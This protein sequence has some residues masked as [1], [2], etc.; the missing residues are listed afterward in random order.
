MVSVARVVVTDAAGWQREM[1][2]GTAGLP[3]LSSGGGNAT[4]IWRSGGVSAGCGRGRLGLVA[5]AGEGLGPERAAVSAER[6][7]AQTVEAGAGAAADAWSFVARPP[8]V[9]SVRDGDRA[10]SRLDADDLGAENACQ[11][12][13]SR[14]RSAA[15]VPITIQHNAI[16]PAKRLFSLLITIRPASSPK[17]QLSA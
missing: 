6:V 11:Q 14:A 3:G 7:S 17:H 5:G 15:S 10:D 8:G 16:V 4:G 13:H 12:D 9:D 2:S 1:R